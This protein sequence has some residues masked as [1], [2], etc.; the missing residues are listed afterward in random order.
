MTAAHMCVLRCQREAKERQQQQQLL[1]FILTHR[2]HSAAKSNEHGETPL[3]L[4]AGHSDVCQECLKLLLR[5]A[6]QTTGHRTVSGKLP[7]HVLMQYR[8]GLPI[9]IEA[10][11]AVLATD[12]SAALEKAKEERISFTFSGRSN[13]A[14]SQSVIIHWSPLERAK[15]QGMAW[16]MTVLDRVMWQRGLW[17]VLTKPRRVN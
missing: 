13:S 8:G 15:E 11:C 14:L 7:L 3:H 16:F 10:V 9:N 6:P 2:P 4:L 12:P 1:R 17:H 5:V